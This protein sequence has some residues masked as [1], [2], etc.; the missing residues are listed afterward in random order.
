MFEKKRRII[1]NRIKRE[2]YI[3]KNF[4]KQRIKRYKLNIKN[5]FGMIFSFLIKAVVFLFHILMKLICF[6]SEQLKKITRL[7]FLA[8]DILLILNLVQWLKKDVSSFLDTKYFKE[9]VILIG[10]NIIVEII[11]YVTSEFAD[12]TEDLY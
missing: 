9:M 2:I 5:F 4:R 7:L 8:G 6:L 11:S 3:F 12:A 10:I 1:K